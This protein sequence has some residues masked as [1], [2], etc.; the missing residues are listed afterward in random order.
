MARGRPVSQVE[1][2]TDLLEWVDHLET[3][4]TGGVSPK[5]P[6]DDPFEGYDDLCEEAARTEVDWK[7][8]EASALVD[9]ANKVEKGTRGEPEYLRKARVLALHR[10]KFEAYK[11]ADA[12]VEARKKAL[13]SVTTRCDALRTVCANTRTQT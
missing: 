11:M 9:Q 2:E 1:V 5:F 13:A 8:Q 6:E 12:K 4:T 10:E 7:V 3:L